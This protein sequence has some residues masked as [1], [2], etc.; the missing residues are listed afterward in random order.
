MRCAP[1]ESDV[2]L[3]SE[4]RSDGHLVVMHVHFDK[5]CVKLEGNVRYISQDDAQREG[6]ELLDKMRAVIGIM[7]GPRVAPGTGTLQ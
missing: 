4:A 7:D 6:V 1:T 2:F 5:Q 3:M